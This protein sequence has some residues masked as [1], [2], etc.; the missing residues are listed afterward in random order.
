M[1]SRLQPQDDGACMEYERYRKSCSAGL[2]E[3]SRVGPP[4]LIFWTIPQSI[5]DSQ[6]LAAEIFPNYVM[7]D[8]QKHSPSLG[9]STVETCLLSK[10]P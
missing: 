4:L 2:G 8:L 6:E 10:G 1:E 9:R 5:R 7:N 3:T